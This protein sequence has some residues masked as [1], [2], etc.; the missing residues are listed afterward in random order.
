MSLIVDSRTVGGQ[1]RRQPQPRR[2][3]VAVGSVDLHPPTEKQYAAAR[4]QKILS[5]DGPFLQ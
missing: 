1:P 2:E 5:H 4:K 3:F